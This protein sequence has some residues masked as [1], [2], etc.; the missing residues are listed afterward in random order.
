MNFK[1]QRYYDHAKSFKNKFHVNSTTLA[2]HVWKMK[3]IKNVTPALTWDVLRTAK[4]YSN[5]KKVFFAPL[6]ETRDHYLSISR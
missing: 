6:R 2:S 1:K 3:K 4:A 5:M